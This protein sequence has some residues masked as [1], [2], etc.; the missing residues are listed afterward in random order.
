MSMKSIKRC[1]VIAW[2]C[3]VSGIMSPSFAQVGIDPE[4]SYASGPN[5]DRDLLPTPVREPKPSEQPATAD[6]T[7]SS[8]DEDRRVHLVAGIDFT[9][10]Y[11]S[12]GL[13]QEDRGILW[14]PFATV[15]IDVI[16]TDD[17]TL[18]PYVGTWHSFHDRATGSGTDD[19]TLDKWY[20]ADFYFGV[21]AAAGSWTFG[22]QYGWFASPNDAFTTVEEL[23]LSV[24]F[25]D[26]EALGDWSMQPSIALIIETGDGTSD[27]FEKG[28]YLQLG[29]TPGMDLGTRE[30]G[31]ALV[32]L[33]VPVTLG[34]SAWDYYQTAD[35]ED[36][37]FGYASVGVKVTYDLPLDDKFGAWSIYASATGALLGDM[38]AEANDDEDTVAIFSA[39]VGVEF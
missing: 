2:A 16:K 36:D 32:R 27:G 30:N 31:D 21:N 29:V 1:H 37:F 17:Y 35:D 9:N 20:E 23:Q 11:Y 38:A 18:T 25:D 24:A 13:R 8:P 7:A 34:L 26:S 19:G 6:T 5:M 15:G 12:R 33:D 22:V 28:A 4:G 39:G 10:A 3:C 14:Q